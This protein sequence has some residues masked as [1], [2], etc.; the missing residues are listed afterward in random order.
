MDEDTKTLLAV[1]ALIYGS[2]NGI[3]LL[4]S[5][6]QS[7]KEKTEELQNALDGTTAAPDY[8]A[9][10][11]KCVLKKLWSPPV[12]VYVL[13]V[14][15]VPVFLGLVVWRGPLK[16]LAWIGLGAGPAS[17]STNGSFVVT[18]SNGGFIVI[19]N[20][21]ST[22]SQSQSPMSRVSIFYWGLLALA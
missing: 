19:P 15:V 12:L 2:S 6:L 10:R 11:R 18:P 22:T 3:G 17:P 5:G 4:R 13:V 1:L 8:V 21:S 20:I 9:K 16:A 14:V 7:L